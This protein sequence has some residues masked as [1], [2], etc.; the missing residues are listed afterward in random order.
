[1]YNINLLFLKYLRLNNLKKLMNMDVHGKR[2]M[3]YEEYGKF[4]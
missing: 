2:D 4:C 3:Q 1:M